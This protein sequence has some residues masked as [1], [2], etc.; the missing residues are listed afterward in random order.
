MTRMHKHTHLIQPFETIRCNS[1]A[2]LLSQMYSNFNHLAI[3]V[4]LHFVSNHLIFFLC[5][6]VYIV[7]LLEQDLNCSNLFI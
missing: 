7:Y 6:Q 2:I 3:C 4:T 5:V 1:S